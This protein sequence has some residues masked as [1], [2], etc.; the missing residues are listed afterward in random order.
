MTK[1]ELIESIER[2]H[3]ECQ[4]HGK[5]SIVIDCLIIPMAIFAFGM[6]IYSGVVTNSIIV[7]IL[8]AALCVLNAYNAVT[9]VKS[10]KKMKRLLREENETYEK[11]LLSLYLEEK[12]DII[13]SK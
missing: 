1:L 3:N 12:S 11:W 4:K 2:N 5:R 6:C 13:E 8:M 10:I 7:R 9:L